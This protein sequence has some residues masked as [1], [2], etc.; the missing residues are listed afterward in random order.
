MELRV[1]EKDAF[2]CQLSKEA[3]GSMAKPRIAC[4]LMSLMED[5]VPSPV[6][7][8]GPRLVIFFPRKMGFASYGGASVGEAFGMEL[9]WPAKGPASSWTI[10]HNGGSR[11]ETMINR[12][13]CLQGHAL[14]LCSFRS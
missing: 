5:G 2:E 9:M 12:D 10:A 13:S 7:G 4:F 8:L 1:F 3:D 6:N 14:R 11:G